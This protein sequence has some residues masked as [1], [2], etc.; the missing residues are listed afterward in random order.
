MQLFIQSGDLGP[1]WFHVAIRAMVLMAESD[2]LL[3]SNQIAERLG[4]DPTTIRKILAK[5][6]KAL[7]VTPHSG[8]YGG[9]SLAKDAAEITVKN[10][11]NAFEPPQVPYWAVP[12]TGSEFYISLIISKAEEQFQQELNQYTL[13]EILKYKAQQS[14]ANP[15]PES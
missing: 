7:L 13:K 6:S 3:K 14:L 4:E 10:V 9:Y 8:R 5:L 1:K 12:S 11:Y 15:N 2:S